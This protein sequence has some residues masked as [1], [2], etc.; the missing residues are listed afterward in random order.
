M[1]VMLSLSLPC[2]QD[3]PMLRDRQN[4]KWG[5]T[6]HVDYGGLAVRFV[7]EILA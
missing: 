2:G 4:G 1:S 5:G 6:R 3:V 7:V